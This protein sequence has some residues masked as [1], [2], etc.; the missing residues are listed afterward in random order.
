LRRTDE[1]NSLENGKERE[2]SGLAEHRV[3]KNFVFDWRRHIW[4]FVCFVQKGVVLFVEVT[5]RN[6]RRD[7]VRGVAE[8]EEEGVQEGGAKHK[9]VRQ[10]MDK[11]PLSVAYKCANTIGQCE[12]TQP[13]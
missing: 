13:R 8:E 1:P 11:N 2:P 7:D 3:P 4:I 10:F 9:V 6:P 5:E 12:Y